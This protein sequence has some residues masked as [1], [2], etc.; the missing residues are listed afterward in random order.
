MLYSCRKKLLITKIESWHKTNGIGSR[1]PTSLSRKLFS[2]VAGSCLIIWVYTCKL[3]KPVLNIVCTSFS[4]FRPVIGKP[5]K[6]LLN[7]ETTLNLYSSTHPNSADCLMF[8]NHPLLYQS[9]SEGTFPPSSLLF[10]ILKWYA[11]RVF[12]SSSISA[13]KNIFLNFSFTL[14]TFFS[15]HRRLWYL[16]ER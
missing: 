4:T 3:Y 14:D 15:A 7:R 10:P 6:A 16:S 13:A 11:M 2:R 1:F 5:Q 12:L 8:D 9:L